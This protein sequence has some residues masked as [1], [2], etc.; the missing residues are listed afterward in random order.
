MAANPC[1]YGRTDGAT[2]NW[3]WEGV[4]ASATLAA[5]S[6]TLRISGVNTTTDTATD[7][8][9]IAFAERNIDAVLLTTNTTD[10]QKRLWYANDFLAL[11][12][13]MSQAGEVFMQ[14]K[15]MNATHNFSLTVPRVYGHSG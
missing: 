8:A 14:V 11:D 7:P 2:E 3:V 9:I 15:N 10:V 12:G 4:G 5:G 6:Y 1:R 13:Y